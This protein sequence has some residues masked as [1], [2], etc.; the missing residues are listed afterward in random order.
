M[1]NKEK[2]LELPPEVI[3]IVKKGEKGFK[4]MAQVLPDGHIRIISE[5]EPSKKK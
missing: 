5:K 4:T 3:E 1:P 2:Q